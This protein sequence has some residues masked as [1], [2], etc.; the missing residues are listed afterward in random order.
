[1][2]AILAVDTQTINTFYGCNRAALNWSRF[3]LRLH[4]APHC[5]TF[6]DRLRCLLPHWQN[7]KF[8]IY[9]VMSIVYFFHQSAQLWSGQYYPYVLPYNSHQQPEGLIDNVTCLLDTELYTQLYISIPHP[10]LNRESLEDIC[11]SRVF[12]H[13][14]WFMDFAPRETPCTGIESIYQVNS[15][16]TGSQKIN[17]PWK[18][19]RM[20]WQNWRGFSLEDQILRRPSLDIPVT[21]RSRDF[22]SGGLGQAFLL[23]ISLPF[24]IIALK[25][26]IDEGVCTE[27]K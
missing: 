1:M 4:T 6:V 14:L 5:C 25:R 20:T 3:P 23:D 18:L 7:L 10:V 12:H 22:H 26:E 15:V 21:V 9:I 17:H 8:S 24:P 2:S 19:F 16:L 13:S 11:S 27:V